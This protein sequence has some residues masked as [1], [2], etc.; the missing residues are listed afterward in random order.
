MSGKLL[1]ALVLI[2]VV[3][4]IL[5]LNVGDDVT[6]TFRLFELTASR[7]IMLFAFTGVGVAVGLLLK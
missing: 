5:L 3:V 1:A 4:I 7:P 2:A 6:V